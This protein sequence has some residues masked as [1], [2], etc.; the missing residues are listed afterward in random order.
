[1]KFYLREEIIGGNPDNIIRT[2]HI[3]KDEADPRSGCLCNPRV[4]LENWLFVEQLPEGT[5]LCRKCEAIVKKKR[6]ME[7]AGRYTEYPLGDV[8][9][10]MPLSYLIDPDKKLAYVTFPEK[11][12][13][14]ES[15]EAI[16][17]LATD[18]RLGEDFGILVDVRAA[19]FAPTVEEAKTIVSA[20]LDPALF[21]ERPTAIVVSQ[22]VQYGMGRMIS[23]LAGLK[24]AVI[25]VFHY[26]VELAEK[27]LRQRS[28][29]E[30]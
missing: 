12:G 7:P 2:A 13:L 29:R 10:T 22:M 23:V 14:A 24:G 19:S 6:R 28:T 5:H 15:L 16:R 17:Q 27:W 9:M 30:E 4:K 3:A 1:M 8:S 26:D 20:I 21:S 11:G 18:E 25:Q